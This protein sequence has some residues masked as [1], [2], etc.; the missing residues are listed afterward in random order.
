MERIPGCVTLAEMVL[1]T[2][3]SAAN[4]RRLLHHTEQLLLDRYRQRTA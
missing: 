4:Y 2:G 1:I 3:L